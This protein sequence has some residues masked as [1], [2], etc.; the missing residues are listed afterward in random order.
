LGQFLSTAL[1]PTLEDL[2]QRPEAA[3]LWDA[4]LARIVWANEAGL[5]YFGCET[6]FDLVDRHFD[7]AEPGVEQVVSLSKTLARGQ[8][9][10]VQLHF[11]SAGSEG[12]VNCSCS[13]HVLSDGR[14]GLL[15]IVSGL[16][17]ATENSGSDI[18]KAFDLLPDAAALI[19]QDGSRWIDPPSQC[20][21]AAAAWRR[22]AGEP[23][24]PP[25][26]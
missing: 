13:I 9:K 19:G 12:P 16:A 1:T 17:E 24:D 15:A 14:P 10:Q 20:R 26:R 8:I 18:I 5:A 22:A 2:R 25:C 7:F 11:P 21:I 6:L 4:A 23:G 3:W